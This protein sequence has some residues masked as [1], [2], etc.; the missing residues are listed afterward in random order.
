MLLSDVV[1][2]VG[3]DWISGVVSSIVIMSNDG[4]WAVV[5]CGGIIVIVVIVAK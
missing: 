4:S 5:D 2:C 3:S 1:I